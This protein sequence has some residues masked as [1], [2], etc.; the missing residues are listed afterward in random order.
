MSPKI[1]QVDRD[2]PPPRHDSAPQELQAKAQAYSPHPGVSYCPTDVCWPTAYPTLTAARDRRDR[3]NQDFP[4]VRD[5]T[6]SSSR[7]YPLQTSSTWSQ[8]RLQ[9]PCSDPASTRQP[10]PPISF[11]AIYV[12]PRPPAPLDPLALPAGD[13]DPVNYSRLKDRLL[14]RSGSSIDEYRE[15]LPNDILQWA[16]TTPHS[17]DPAIA[18][19]PPD[20]VTPS[21]AE[22]VEAAPPAGLPAAFPP[23]R[24]ASYEER[25][26]TTTHS[27]DGYHL[28][29]SATLPPWRQQGAPLGTTVAS[30]V[31]KDC[32]DSRGSSDPRFPTAAPQISKG[33]PVQAIA[34]LPRVLSMLYRYVS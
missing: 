1:E 15:I 10:D 22:A 24:R 6:I 14:T 21:S 25:F 4:G 18:P 19:S 29:E 31:R 33:V 11:P 26:G 16:K 27:L 9:G 34:D 12:S 28:E 5:H 30:T 32:A 17:A 2:A 20:G 8:A 13:A 23:F 7:N 3:F